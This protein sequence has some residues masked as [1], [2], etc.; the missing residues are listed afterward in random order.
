MNPEPSPK[1]PSNK[2]RPAARPATPSS[3]PAPTKVPP[4]FRAIDWWAFAICFVIVG[5]IYFL[6]LAPE[7]TLEDSGELTT[8]SFWAGI[9]H[10]PGYPFWAIYS[11]L[12]TQLVP[13]GNVAWRVELGEAAAAAM[14]CSL[15]AFM[16][17]RGG[18]MLM[19]SIEELRGM[20]GKWE[21]A[22]C[23]VCGVTAG[24]L[25]AL[26]N[27]MWKE[28]VAINRISLFGVPWL[29]IV[30]LS[31]LRWIYAPQQRGYLYCAMFFFGI[32][33]TIHQTLIVAAMGIEIG[34]ACTQPKLGRDLFFGNSLVFVVGLIARHTGVWTSF[35]QVTPMVVV[36]Y[37]TVGVC[38]LLACIALA[39]QTRGLMTEWKACGLMALLWL[40]GASFYFY[41][42]IA[43]MTNPPMEWGYPRTVEGFFHALTR[44]QYDKINPTDVIHDPARF[45]EQLKTLAA[46]VAD[47]FNWVYMFFAALPFLFFFKLQRR[48]RN[49]LI[50]VAAIYPFLGVLLTIFFN[51]NL[52]RQMTDLLKVFFASSHTVVA[53]LI[54]YGLALT[55]AYMATHYQKFR[56]W[57]AVGGGAA[58]VLALMCLLETTGKHYFG[59]AG[60]V[61][62]GDLPHWIAQSFAPG[63]YGLP[64]YAN[65]LLVALPLVFLAALAVYRT[66]APLFVTLALFAVMP[67]YSGLSHWFQSEQAQSLV[68]LLVRP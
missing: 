45:L 66:R 10:P 34:I 37:N 9:P 50:T 4:L 36:I 2:P 31:L 38:S 48:E 30:L 43:G 35:A 16:V 62:L 13:I 23:L 15:L 14:G 33:A 28:S 51:A 65:L 29:I 8:G 40:A 22:I 52:D 24:L 67:V 39:I 54:G 1:F 25:M 21:N 27:S 68:W 19:E 11:W 55:A 57:G 20:V 56:L 3:P 7:V 41:E 32:C 47:A 6:T 64:I 12:W 58:L 46:G 18:S 26:D 60:E 63:Q 53:I 42:A 49:W 61:S 44:G 5:T 17:S 59:V